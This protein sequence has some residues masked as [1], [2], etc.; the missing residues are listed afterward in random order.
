MELDYSH[1][2]N[3]KKNLKEKV[4]QTGKTIEV[5]NIEVGKSSGRLQLAVDV[6]GSFNGGKTNFIRHSLWQIKVTVV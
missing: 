2:Q 3:V 5:V 4:F 6:K 1:L